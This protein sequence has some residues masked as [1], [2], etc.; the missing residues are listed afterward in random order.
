MLYTYGLKL[1]LKLLMHGR[2]KEPARYLAVPVN[3]WRTLEYGLVA[4]AGQFCRDDRVLDIGSPKLFSL[5]LADRIGAEV[6]STDIEDYFIRE[7]RLLQRI[8]RV[9]ARRYHPAVEDGRALSFADNSFTKVYSI[10]VLEHIPDDGDSR[11]AAEIGRVLAPG[12][13]AMLTV[14]FAPTSRNE[15]TTPR[16]Y[17]HRSSTTGGNG[18][19]FYQRRYSEADLYRRLI[20]PSGLTLSRLQ[21]VGERVLVDSD[22]E[23][24]EFLPKPT[25]PIQPLVSKLAH[26]TPADSWRSLKKPLCAFLVLEKKADQSGAGAGP[27]AERSS[28]G[29]PLRV[30][31]QR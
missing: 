18:T 8:Q 11:C 22:R 26:T 24:C 27:C 31:N 17:W 30:G 13:M 16:F 19:V 15:F 12:G 6:F 20:E 4:G 2:W 25:G 14:P 21:Y 7:Y 3:Y 23:L 29:S 5:F 28:P 10:S 1:G 9:S